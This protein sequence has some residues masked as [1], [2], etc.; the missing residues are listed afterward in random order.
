MI[1]LPSDL[2]KE[3]LEIIQKITNKKLKEG[4]DGFNIT[5]NNFPAAQQ[6]VMHAHFHIIPRKKNMV[7][8]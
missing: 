5:M 8:Y 7:L 4:A 1:D 2:G 6:I 3:L